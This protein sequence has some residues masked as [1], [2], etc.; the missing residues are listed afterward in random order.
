VGELR[1]CAPWGEGKIPAAG[2][3]RQGGLQERREEDAG[4]SRL[5]IC[6]AM[7]EGNFSCPWRRRARLSREDTRNASALRNRGRRLRLL[8]DLTGAAGSPLATA[9]GIT[10][11][12]AAAI[13]AESAGSSAG[14]GVG[15]HAGRRV[16]CVVCVSF[17]F[18]CNTT[19]MTHEKNQ[20]INN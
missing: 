3:V 6:G 9:S 12:S 14:P 20:E 4:G 19:N 7:D 13:G 17:P 16:V 10:H 5:E 18:F 1:A 2:E 8:L 11:W 15:V